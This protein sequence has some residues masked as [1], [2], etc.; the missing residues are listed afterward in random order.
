MPAV[1]SDLF[2][3]PLAERHRFEFISTHSSVTDATVA[4]WQRVVT[5]AR[6]LLKLVA[7]SLGRGPRVVHVHTAT[8]GSWYR[9]SL[10]VLA[11]RA[12]G[13]PVILHV[14]A[15]PGDIAAFC[16]RIGPVRRWLFARAFRAADRV[17]SVSTAS[18]HAIERELGVTGIV[19]L[20]S[21]P[22]RSRLEGLQ[23]HVPGSARAR[24]DAVEVLYLGGFADPVK[25]GRV[26]LDAI[27][28]VL[29]AAPRVS[30]SLAGPGPAPPEVDPGRVRWLGWLERP[31]VAAAMAGAD[32]VVLPSVSEGLPV[33]LLEALALGRAVVATRV[34]G[35]PEVIRDDV[36]GALVEAGDATALAR[37]IAALAEDPERRARLGRAGLQRAAELG[38]DE[39]A[40]EP[41]DALYRELV[42]DAA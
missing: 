4:R 19:T 24:G 30:V 26:L 34:G 38:R 18:A 32:I 28:R 23:P 27:P 21:V 35:I 33:V 41:L 31:R 6:G 40:Y 5:F 39:E 2:A 25:G 13:K 1:L 12:A 22:P 8:R 16:Q 7:W 42:G 20:P 11:V 9:K 29:A 10:C 15:G 14:H 17:V 3:S 37:A 36:E